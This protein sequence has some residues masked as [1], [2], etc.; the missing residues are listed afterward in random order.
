MPI[1]EFMKRYTRR[2]SRPTGDFSYFENARN[3]V[4]AG[5][6]GNILI[7][8][9]SFLTTPIDVIKTK[10]MTSRDDNMRS[11]SACVKRIMATDGPLGFFKGVT[12][13]VA[14]IAFLSSIFFSVYEFFRARVE[15]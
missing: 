7:N 11:I 15:L 4:V 12:L 10:L 3:G 14:N 1:Y 9:A 8:T 6:I 13:R 5:S 2:H